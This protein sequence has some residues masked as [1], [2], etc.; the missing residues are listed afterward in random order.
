MSR[1]QLEQRFGI[2]LPVVAVSI[3]AL[4]GLVAL[5]VD[6]GRLVVAK[7]ECQAAADSA[8]IAGARSLD[9]TQNLPVATNNA[10]GAATACKILGE[11][12]GDGEVTVNH[13]SYHYDTGA[14]KFVPQIPAVAPDNFNLTQVTVTH[15]VNLTF[16]RVLGRTMSTVSA[17]STAAHRPRDIAIVLDYSGSM[18]NE[19]DLWNNESYL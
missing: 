4:V 7:T 14:Q 11:T 19:S 17:T 16:A 3:V 6:I 5:A 1:K 9:G 10:V 15:T 2:V 8:A 12:I 13:G 18:N